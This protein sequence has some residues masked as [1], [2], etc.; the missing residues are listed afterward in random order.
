[1]KIM[2]VDDHDAIRLLIRSILTLADN[3]KSLGKGSLDIVDF[4]SGE[5]AI[6]Q[7]TAENPD[8]VL[9]DIELKTMSGF[10]VLKAILEK[11]PQAK[12]IIVTSYD[13]PGFRR[14]AKKLGAIDFVPKDQLSDIQP[15]LRNIT[16]LSA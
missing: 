12:I 8:F 10:F 4:E 16:T 7:Y 2:I 9:L 13:N 14:N 5:E 1:M 15:I 3:E 11:D 6:A